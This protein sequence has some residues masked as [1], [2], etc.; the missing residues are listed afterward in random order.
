MQQPQMV[1]LVDEQDQK[2]GLKEK[3]SAHLGKGTL[4]RAFSVFLHNEKGEILVQKRA[5]TK[6]LWPLFWSN[7]V[8][9]HPRPDEAILA[10]AKRRIPEEV[11]LECLGLKE[12]YSFIYQAHYKDIGSEHEFCHVVVGQ[13]SGKLWENPEEVAAIRWMM[14]EQIADVM[15]KNPDQFTP[16]FKMEM[17]EL[18]NRLVLIPSP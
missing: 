12:I 13:A 4:H 15:K 18:I 11:G 5:K 17:P 1:V 2:I 14:P 7:T 9:S 3:V 6:M 10:A 8:C 16:W